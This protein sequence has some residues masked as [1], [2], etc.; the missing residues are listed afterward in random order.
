VVVVEVGLVTEEAVPEILP[1]DVVPRPVGTLGVGE[2]DAR[3][4]VA[5]VGIAPDVVVA[6]GRAERCPARLLEP[7]VLVG[8]VVHDQ[9]GQHADVAPVGLPQEALDVSRGAVVR[10]DAEVVCNVVPVVAQGRD[11]EGQEP[12]SI[13]AEVL[14]IIEFLDKS[15]KIAHAVAVRIV[16]S[17]DVKLVDDCVL[18]PIGLLVVHKQPPC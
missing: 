1:R 16:K 11:V 18:V 7:G 14:K 5:L 9:I 12:D 3:V 2:D 17:L 6:L 10:V 15:L 13:D 8:G 4:A